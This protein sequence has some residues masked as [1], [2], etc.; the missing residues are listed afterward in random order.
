MGF[1]S[2]NPALDNII[3][4]DSRKLCLVFLFW[5]QNICFWSGAKVVMRESREPSYSIKDKWNAMKEKVLACIMKKAHKLPSVPPA[6]IRRNLTDLIVL[7][8]NYGVTWGKNLIPQIL[9]LNPG[10]WF[11]MQ[12]IQEGF[13]KCQSCKFRSIHEQRRD[14]LIPSGSWHSCVRD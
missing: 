7:L 9:S 6:W 5:R 3:L 8:Q 14:T 12:R 2:H 13:A 11:Q 4:I 1:W 10:V